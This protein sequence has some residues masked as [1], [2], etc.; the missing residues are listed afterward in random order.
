MLAVGVLRA[1]GDLGLRVPADLSLAS[2]DDIPAGPIPGA[3]G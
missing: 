2:Y 3:P 1:A